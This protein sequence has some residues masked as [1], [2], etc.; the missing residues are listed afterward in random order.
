MEG[1]TEMAAWSGSDR[2]RNMSRKMGGKE[3][4]EDETATASSVLHKAEGRG[5]SLSFNMTHI[6]EKQGRGLKCVACV[7]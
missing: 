7:L 6:S 1:R 2:E 5:L 4:G 3:G